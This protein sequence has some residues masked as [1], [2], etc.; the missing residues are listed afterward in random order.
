M[1][2]FDYKVLLKLEL[3]ALNHLLMLLLEVR[4]ERLKNSVDASDNVESSDRESDSEESS[5][6]TSRDE[7]DLLSLPF[8]ARDISSELYD[9]ATWLDEVGSFPAKISVRSRM[10]MADDL[11]FFKSYPW[12]KKSFDLTLTYLKNQ[13]NLRKQGQMYNEKK[14]ASYALYGFPWAFLIIILN[15]FVWIYEVVPYLGK[16]IGK[17]S[18][19]LLLIPHLLRWYTLKSDN[20]VE[21]DP[22]KYKGR[23]TK[24]VHPYLTPTPYT[25]EV[26]DTV[27]DVLKTQLKG[28]T[29]LTAGDEYLGDHNIIQPCVNSVSSRQ[30]NVLS[31][32]NDGSIENLSDR[33]VSLEQSMVEVAANVRKEKLRRIEKNKKTTREDNIVHV[34][35]TTFDED[36]ATV[37]E[38]FAAIDEYFTDGVNEVTVDVA[39]KVTGDHVDEVAVDAV[40]EVTGDVVDEVEIDGVVGDVVACAVDPVAVGDVVDEVASAVDD[41]EGAV[42]LV[43]VDVIDEVVVTVDVVA[44][45]VDD[46]VGTVDPMTVDVVDEVAVTIDVVAVDDVAGDEVAG[47]VDPVTVDISDEVA[48]DAIDEVT[49]ENEEEKTKKKSVDDEEEKEEDDCAENSVNVMSIVM[50]INGEINGEAKNN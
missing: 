25:N 12:E 24:I 34:N 14:N 35:I 43:A 38:D 19:T 46:V 41:V 15:Y 48:D 47:A 22:F 42:D 30:K 31:T 4:N 1:V 17:S 10:T 9:L 33:V 16:Y 50:E 5:R 3:E 45:A 27:I 8:C 49:E 18:D 39:D 40:D 21:G 44:G 32:S 13:I 28:V 7:D 11:D 26:N 23:S 36:L 6:D 2:F 37:D 29:V 20:I